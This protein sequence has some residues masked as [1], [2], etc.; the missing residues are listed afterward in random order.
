MKEREQKAFSWE[1]TPLD[2]NAGLFEGYVAVFGNLD[3]NGDVIDRGAFTKTL[4]D[5]RKKKAKEA[6]PYLFPILWQHHE[7]EPIGGFTDAYEDDHGLFIRGQFD[8]DTD[9]GRQAYSGA[10]KG[11]LRGLSIGYDPI[12][13]VYDTKKTRHLTEIRLWE[14]SPVTFPANT[15]AMMTSVKQRDATMEMKRVSGRMDWPIADRG[16]GWDAGA[17]HARLL[18]WAGGRDNFS[19]SK[20]AS[21]H[22]WSPEGDAAE[23]I[24]EY[25]FPFC[26][27]VDGSPKAVFRALSAAAGRLN[28]ASGVDTGAIKSKIA[29]YYRKC[30]EAFDD[31]SMREQAAEMMKSVDL[32]G[33][34]PEHLRASPSRADDDQ[35][36]M[37]FTQTTPRDLQQLA[38]LQA[39]MAAAQSLNGVCSGAEGL[40]ET[41]AGACGL[42]LH[43]KAVVRPPSP[44]VAA[45]LA[46]IDGLE[47]AVKA[48]ADAWQE[49]DA[50]TDALMSLLGLPREDTGLKETAVPMYMSQLRSAFELKVGRQLSNGNRSRLLRIAEGLQSHYEDIV[51]ILK[52]NDKSPEPADEEGAEDQQERAGKS[53]SGHAEKPEQSATTSSLPTT[54]PDTDDTASTLAELEALLF[55]QSIDLMG[56][57]Y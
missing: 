40:T 33:A 25:K 11:Y 42:S 29:S 15:Q 23:N 4:G 20:F 44:P 48:V 8:L 19:A 47:G 5:A 52:E 51:G 1:V 31:P 37:S 17:A 46:G 49:V 30:A 27:I 54:E 35:T 22:F 13:S 41:L 36:E 38:G 53:L 34:P 43:A 28:Q 7:D 24:S 55:E 21:V 2:E 6:H 18:E 50:Q 26:D 9:R 45:L 12:K 32:A 39:L 3:Q 14:G 16:H 57:G 10:K 56:R